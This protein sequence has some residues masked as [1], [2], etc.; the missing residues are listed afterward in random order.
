MQ[1][2]SIPESCIE[3]FKKIRSALTGDSKLLA[4]SKLQTYNKICELFDFGQRDFAENYVQEAV[5]K[6]S[7]SRRNGL[8][9]RWHFIG[10]IQTNKVKSV[11][12]LFDLIHSVDSIKLAQALAKFVPPTQQQKILIQVNLS[13]EPSKGGFSEEEIESVLTQISDL[14]NLKVVGFMTMPPESE[15]AS[16]SRPYF[17]RLRALRD[18][19]REKYPSLTELSMGT[20]QDFQIALEE[21]ATWIRVGASI[22]GER[23][24]KNN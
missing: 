15:N 4:V 14:K 6:V 17:A 24:S 7:M 12:G 21:G 16:D 9:I 11:V 5:V 22:F 8:P 23:P 20:S 13:E 18:A 19:H 10:H 3:N 1:N 2:D